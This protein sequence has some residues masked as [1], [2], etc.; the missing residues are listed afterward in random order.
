M[1]NASTY[2]EDRTLDYWLKANSAT[3]SSPSTVYLALFAGS[4]DSAGHAAASVA[5]L[6]E[7]VLTD[8]VSASGTA[9]ARQSIAFGSISNGSVSNSGTVTYPTATGAG[10][11]TVSHVAVMDA[12]STGNILFYG[13]LTAEKLIAVGDTFQITATNLTISLA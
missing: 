13:A 1:S 4:A 12:A 11:G 8:E 3:T 10:F 2:T 7:G 9:Y 6:E 5:N